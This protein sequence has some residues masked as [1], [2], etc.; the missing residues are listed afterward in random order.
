MARC[1]PAQENSVCQQLSQLGCRRNTWTRLG[2]GAPGPLL[3]ENMRGQAQTGL[4]LRTQRA[5]VKL[6]LHCSS[7]NGAR[8]ERGKAGRHTARAPG[9]RSLRSCLSKLPEMHCLERDH[10]REPLAATDVMSPSEPWPQADLA[11]RWMRLHAGDP[12]APAQ[13]AE[14]RADPLPPPL[15]CSPARFPELKSGGESAAEPHCAWPA[16][17]SFQLLCTKN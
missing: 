12:M 1:N 14:R 15:V 17:L 6:S 4:E 3:P 10:R 8:G 2:S 11:E 9:S 13:A 5:K 7:L 16:L